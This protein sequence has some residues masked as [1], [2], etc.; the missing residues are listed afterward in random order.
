MFAPLRQDDRLIKIDA[1]GQRVVEL[2]LSWY[3]KGGYD[4][5]YQ[6]LVDCLT[7]PHQDRVIV[8]VQRSSKL[9]LIDI[10]KNR[11]VGTIQLADR[12]GNPHLRM[13][14]TEDFIASDYDTLCRVDIRS[15][16]TIRSARLQGD[17]SDGTRQ[18]VGDY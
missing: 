15:M 11:P 1:I 6:G 16:S 7:L 4:L 12:G 13:R 10:E 17:A 9:V 5:V 8:S 14:T 2:E 3:L 18:F